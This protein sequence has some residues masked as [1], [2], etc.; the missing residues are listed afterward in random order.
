MELMVKVAEKLVV[1]AKEINVMLK[2][3]DVMMDVNQAIWGIHAKIVSF[4]T[5]FE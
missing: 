4:L 3:E 5:K 1:S 2:P